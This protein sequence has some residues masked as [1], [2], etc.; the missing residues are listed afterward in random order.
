M[1]KILDSINLPDDIQRLS[2]K[3]LDILSG[4]IRELILKVVSRTGGHLSSNL[5][6]VELTLALYKVFDFSKDKLIFDVSHQSYTHKIITGRKDQFSTLRQYNGISGYTNPEESL[7]DTFIAGHSSTSLPL[8]LGFVI[9]RE[10]KKEDYEIVSLIGDGALTS[11]EAYEG[12]NNL[13]R[14]GKKVIVVL[15][16]NE[17]SI[18]KNVGALSEYLSRMRS[19]SF[20]QSLKMKLPRTSLGRKVKLSIKDLFLPTVFFEE[21]GFTYLGPVDG[22]DV[23]KLVET[24]EGTKNIPYPIVVH[25]VTK[26]GKGYSYAEDNP[27]KFHSAPPF[28]IKTGIR[29]NITSQKTFSELFGKAL[30]KESKKD[31]RIFAITAAMSD[32]TKTNLTKDLFP[33][34][35]IDV[36]IAEQCAVTAAAGMAKEG[37]KPVVAIYSTFLQRAY[38]QLVHDVGILNLPVVFALDRAGIVSSDG[39]T[40]QGVFDLSYMRIIP[41][42]VV[43]APRD[44]EELKAMLHFSL[45]LNCPSSIRYPKDYAPKALLPVKPIKLGKGELIYKGEDLLI[46]SIGTMFY[47]ALRAREALEKMGISTGLIN[48]RFAKPVDEKLILSEAKKSRKVITIEDNSVKGGFGSAISELLSK[49]GIEVRIVGIE[50]FFPEQGERRFLMNK[51]GLS[52]EHIIKVGEKF[53]K[54]KNR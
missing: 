47:E 2:Y 15:N 29:K 23:Q 21:L 41:N 5:G 12:L 19:S 53:A 11:G 50:D 9:A 7:F 49:E 42:F 10:F 44:G 30:V 32:G 37:L 28:E 46:V 20:Y 33:E 38:D 22:H 1:S 43:M 18:S 8:A 45:Q 14:R 35:F 36:G 17:M 24:F 6:T 31:K 27:T 25:V 26:K 3:E 48:A 51:Y 54:E 4:E 52:A 16:D 40:H 34:R 39:P 13:G